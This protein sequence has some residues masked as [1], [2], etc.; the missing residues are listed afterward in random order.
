MPYDNSLNTGKGRSF[1]K[2]AAELLSIHF[3]VLFKLD[4]PIKIGNP[5][6][7]HCFDLVSVN[8]QYVGECKNY[9]WTE[10]GN[11]PSA[12]MAFIN[13]AV[14]Y[15]SFLPADKI[16][17]IA[18]RKDVHPTRGETLAEYYHRTYHHLLGDIFIIE[19]D[20]ES[21]SLREIR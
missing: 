15:L 10:A 16:R 13:E 7:E 14:L 20:F 5:P 9:S 8:L 1:Q 18:M 21:D 6:K 12:K 4:Y 17:F 11:V 19:I 2:Q 3:G